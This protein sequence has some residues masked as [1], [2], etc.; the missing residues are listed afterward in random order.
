MVKWYS[1]KNFYSFLDK[2]TVDL[3]L[4]ANSS[5][6][7]FEVNVGNT[8]ISKVIAILGANGAG[9]SN[10]L[11]PLAFL[12]WFCDHSFTKLESRQSLP[13]YTHF[14]NKDEPSELEVC[15]IDQL[16]SG[17]I[18][19]KYYVKLSKQKVYHE[20]LKWKTSRQFS[21]VFYR[22][23]DEGRDEYKV[24]STRKIDKE[25]AFPESELM[26]V[27][28]NASALS[29]FKR[30]GNKFA[31]LIIHNFKSIDNN[32]TIHGKNNFDYSRVINATEFYKENDDIFQ[33]AL[34]YLRRMDFGLNSI[35]LKEEE[36]I[37]QKTGEKNNIVNPY[38]VHLCREH[39]YEIPF[40][41]ESTGTQACF[42][43]MSDLVC[44]FEWGGVAL[45]DELDSDLH[46]LM[47]NEIIDMF[48]NESIN[49]QNAQLIFSCHSP[50]VLKALKKHNVYVVEKNDAV[51]DC[52]RLD[53]V[54]GL[55][56]Q[57]NLYSKY[58]TGAIGGVPEISL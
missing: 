20:E 49:K 25:L 51:S 22:I 28:E 27:P 42:D 38:G 48:A 39:E 47:V 14:S 31:E 37:N 7:H 41:L 34:K 16:D 19:F 17:Y 1:F 30:K 2:T 45:I 18:E 32:L 12:R 11:K 24:K 3:T 53:Q 26:T 54:E 33:L 8:R 35:V 29:Y 6:S 56:A 9:K 5:E 15:F 21:S 44:A 36:V 57:D 52:W 23:Y 4:H 40:Y 13:F 50:E 46:P 10:L 55:R 43:I 58:I